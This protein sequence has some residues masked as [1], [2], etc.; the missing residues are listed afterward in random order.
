MSHSAPATGLVVDEKLTRKIAALAR[1]ELTDQEVSTFT[2]QLGD[3]LKYVDQL[4]KADVTGVEPMYQAL[5]PQSELQPF[6]EDI[7]RPSP[8]DAHGEPKVLEHAPEVEGGG[9]KVPPIL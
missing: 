6:R 8:T 7:V 3:I 5:G 1:L 4:Q 9:Y 2:G